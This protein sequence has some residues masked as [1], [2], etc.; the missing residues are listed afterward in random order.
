LRLTLVVDPCNAEGYDAIGNAKTLNE[1]GSFK[2]GVLVILI[3]NGGQ[4]LGYGLEIE[5]LTREVFSK[6]G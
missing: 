3:F 1:V 5:L 2:L 6:Y 4:H